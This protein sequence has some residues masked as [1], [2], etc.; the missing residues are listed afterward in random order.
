MK[1]ITSP[2]WLNHRNR[3]NRRL[4]DRQTSGSKNDSSNANQ[5]M[6]RQ[7]QLSFRSGLN[8]SAWTNSL[9]AALRLLKTP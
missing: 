9:S 8:L 7:L 6:S 2:P 3:R 4:I 5:N 1:K